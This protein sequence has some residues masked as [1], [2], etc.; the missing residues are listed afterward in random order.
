MGILFGTSSTQT[1][2]YRENF[3]QLS[4]SLPAT[5]YF[6]HC[7]PISC[8]GS[9]RPKLTYWLL[10]SPGKKGFLGLSLLEGFQNRV[11]GS[12]LVDHNWR[13]SSTMYLGPHVV[14]HTVII[15]FKQLR[16]ANQGTCS[17]RRDNSSSLQMISWKLLRANWSNNACPDRR[18]AWVECNSMASWRRGRIQGRPQLWSRASAPVRSGG[19]PR[20]R[21]ADLV[22]VWPPITF[23]E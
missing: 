12:C 21:V 7:H 10:P 8:Q 15:T 2:Q 19:A 18:L 20:R 6:Q 14:C 13:R 3:L 17:D 4:R 1:P 22:I 11:V 5:A 23:N 9:R 16:R